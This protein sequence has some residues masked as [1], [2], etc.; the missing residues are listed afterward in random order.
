MSDEQK[1]TASAIDDA[2]GKVLLD[3]L[4]N[5]VTGTDHEGNAV[6]LT[7]SPALITAAIKYVQSKGGGR[8]PAVVGTPAGKLTERMNKHPRLV[9]TNPEILK[10]PISELDERASA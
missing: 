1:S 7:P 10:A 5:G 9:G 4:E 8:D 6:K 2:V 3:A